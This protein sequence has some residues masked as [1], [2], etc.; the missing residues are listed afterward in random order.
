MLQVQSLHF[1][2]VDGSAACDACEECRIFQLAITLLLLRTYLLC[3]PTRSLCTAL[4]GVQLMPQIVAWCFTQ[5]TAPCVTD[6]IQQVFRMY[7]CVCVY[8][9]NVA[10]VYKCF[11]TATATLNYFLYIYN[12]YVLTNICTPSRVII[13]ALMCGILKSLTPLPFHL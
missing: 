1:E 3:T 2:R 9:P 4:T 6:C 5:S 8:D 11:W 12:I 10:H 7:V 13:W